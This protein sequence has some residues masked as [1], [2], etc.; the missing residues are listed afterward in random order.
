MRKFN[1]KEDRALLFIGILGRV[2]FHVMLLRHRRIIQP[3]DILQGFAPSNQFLFS[4]NL[5]EDIKFMKSYL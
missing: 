2:I 5:L 1:S 4:E 3:E